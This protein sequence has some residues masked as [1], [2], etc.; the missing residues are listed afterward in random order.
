MIDFPDIS[1]VIPTYNRAHTIKRCLDSVLN[2]SIPPK[3]VVVVD[4]GSSDDTRAAVDAFNDDRIKYIHQDNAGANRAR[5]RGV[6]EAACSWIAFQDADDIWLP[7]KL[8]T[9]IKAHG[10]AQE[11]GCDSSVV[12]SS[13]LTYDGASG[14]VSLKPSHAVSAPQMTILKDPI[15]ESKLLV[16]NMISTQTLLVKRDVLMAAGKFDESLKRFQDW[17]LAIRLAGKSPFVFV[18]EPLVVAEALAGSISS[19]YNHGVK[20]R[21]IFLEKYKALFAEYPSQQKAAKKALRI[22]QLAQFLKR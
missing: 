14:S 21:A 4:D 6:E 1:V 20:T 5:N 8:E 7:H 15:G 3:E 18:S 12:F 13:F 16:E 9:L 19:N 2:Q 17:D 11:E 10:A 22:R